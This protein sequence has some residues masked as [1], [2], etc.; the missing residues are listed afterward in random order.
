MH[1]QLQGLCERPVLGRCFT[2]ALV[3]LP[4]RK[5]ESV[6]KVFVHFDETGFN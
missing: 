1:K 6:P 2:A 3:P 4:A 5:S